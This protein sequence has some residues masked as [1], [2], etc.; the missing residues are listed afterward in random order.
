MGRAAA[1]TARVPCA[2]IFNECPRRRL[3]SAGDSCRVQPGDASHVRTSTLDECIRRVAKLAAL[4]HE[5]GVA[6][7]GEIDE[8]PCGSTGVAVSQMARQRIQN[9]QRS[10]SK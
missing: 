4:A 2:L 7:E 6:I 5:H 8:L 1:E 3:G 10:L 9:L